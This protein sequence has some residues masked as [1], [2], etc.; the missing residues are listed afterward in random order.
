MKSTHI[1]VLSSVSATLVKVTLLHGCFLRTNGT[2]FEQPGLIQHINIVILFLT[3]NK[4]F[5][6]GLASLETKSSPNFALALSKF[7]RINFYSP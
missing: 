1:G 5:S 3:F 2:Y 6:D 7:K 4:Y